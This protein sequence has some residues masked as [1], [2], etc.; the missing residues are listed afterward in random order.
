ME[1][2]TDR[3]TNS[4]FRAS[5]VLLITSAYPPY[6]A[7]GSYR[8]EKVAEALANDGHQV[9]VVTT[10]LPGERG[11]ERARRGRLM[12]LTVPALRHPV[13]ALLA[14]RNYFRS[15]RV[16]EGSVPSGSDVSNTS[17]E[18]LQQRF[19]RRV[20]SLMFVPDDSQLF[21]IAAIARALRLKQTFDVV[22]TTAPSFS[23]NIAGYVYKRL[24][25]TPWVAEYRD[26]WA[27]GQSNDSSGFPSSRASRALNRGLERRCLAAADLVVSVSEG[28]ADTLR[29]AAPEQPE[30][31]FVMVRNG[32]PRL[33]VGSPRYENERPLTFLYLGN[34]YLERNPLPMI[35]ALA[36]LRRT[37][38]PLRLVFA[39][40]C[41]TFRGVSIA[42]YAASRGVGDSVS[43][44]PWVSQPEA[45][46]LMES[47]DAFLLLAH[48]Q[49][50]QVPNKLYEYL[51]TRKPIV[52]IV[53]AQG[54]SA[55]L[56]RK[57]GGHYIITANTC[58]AIIPVLQAAV[59]DIRAAVA[60]V[61]EFEALS[62]LTTE[63]QMTLLTQH[64]RRHGL[65]GMT[66]D[67]K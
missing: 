12:V 35:D 48:A 64:L 51:G 45:Q 50:L 1:Y 7:S 58:D 3:E 8:A 11:Q 65:L 63:Y 2:R 26:P 34:L 47:A 13:K 66:S 56:L 37:L 40:N 59:G 27:H 49:P 36:V 53:D 52:A 42:E 28:I 20:M 67:S 61:G 24:T 6:P 25:R 39:G 4:G 21:A 18:S 32:I 44:K 16:T 60:P 57:T 54:E 22:Y 19:L 15:P 33:G 14:V 55:G 23:A 9:V 31:K 10:R 29:A 5:R 38:P 62:A 30:M 41:D 17:G 46:N 43:V